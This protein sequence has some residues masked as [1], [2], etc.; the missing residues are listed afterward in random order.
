MIRRTKVRCHEDAMM[1]LFEVGY[2]RAD[3]H[4]ADASNAF[5]P[6]PGQPRGPRPTIV[7]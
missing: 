7:M 5:L 4:A 2:T 1:L 6:P 3:G